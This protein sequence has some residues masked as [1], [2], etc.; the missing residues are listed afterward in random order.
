[1][2]R[3]QDELD[4]MEIEAEELRKRLAR[5]KWAQKA[6]AR[7]RQEIE[8]EVTDL[9]TQLK[10]TEEEK[11]RLEAELEQ[12]KTKMQF[13]YFTLSN[14]D[15]FSDAL[16]VYTGST[17]ASSKMLDKRY[18]FF[19]HKVI[20]VG[21][22]LIKF[23]YFSPLKV[24]RYYNPMYS[25]QLLKKELVA[26]NL[27]LEMFSLALMD[28]QLVFLTGGLNVTENG[29]SAEVHVYDIVGN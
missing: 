14:V 20:Q 4:E 7:E 18:E 29:F 26:A 9:S 11:M 16:F 21:N 3:V 27:D 1:M 8:T 25:S 10:Q 15:V 12:A 17:Q 6:K 23:Q 28:E 13:K 24:T 22:D 5:I 2:N 19:E